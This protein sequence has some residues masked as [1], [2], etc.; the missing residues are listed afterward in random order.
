MA[1]CVITPLAW[2]A[3]MFVRAYFAHR[4]HHTN[5]RVL[6]FELS[7]DK[8]FSPLKEVKT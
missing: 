3:S 6:P 5:P 7:R 8:M 1:A 2:G 4:R